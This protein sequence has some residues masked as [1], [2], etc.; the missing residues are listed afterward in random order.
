MSKKYNVLVTFSK[1]NEYIQK[2]KIKIP[3]NINFKCVKTTQTL[4]LKKLKQIIKNFDGLICGDETINKEILNNGKKLKVISKW[5]TGIDSIDLDLCKKYN[6]KVY[7]TP[8]AFTD[9]V[10]QIALAFILLFSREIFRTHNEIKKKNWPK[11]SGN[12][13]KNQTVGIIGLGKIGLKLANYVNKLGMKVVFN[14]VKK[15]KKKYFIKKNLNNLVKQSDYI[16]ICCDLN[17]TSYQL[18]NIKHFLKMKKN[19][20][21]I[22]VARGKIIK[23]IDLI[24]AL[25]KNLIKN[26]ALDVFEKEPLSI[27]SELRRFENVI[28][29]SHNAFNTV[30]NVEKVNQNTLKNITKVLK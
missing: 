11:I 24:K 16:C 22:N 30:E 21:L 20:S 18:L 9:S 8:N 27:N 6:V 14:D 2:N 4:G 13:L 25:K 23:E 10:A 12:L 29:S 15:I 3:K 7:N 19:S 26:V 28:L 17:E 1:M 5:G